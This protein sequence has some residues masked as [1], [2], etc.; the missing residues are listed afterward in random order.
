M[1]RDA[2]SILAVLVLSVSVYGGAREQETRSTA[3]SK[4]MA[5]SVEEISE[6]LK[7]LETPYSKMKSLSYNAE[8][9]RTTVNSETEDSWNFTYRAPSDIRIEYKSPR[10]RIIVINKRDMWEYLPDQRVAMHTGLSEK[11]QAERDAIILKVMSRVSVSGL[12]PGNY[13]HLV[14]QVTA[15]EK[16]GNV[17]TIKGDQSPPFM[18][19]IN[20]ARNAMLVS[21]LYDS[22][23]NLKLKTT[24]SEHRPVRKGFWMPKTIQAITSN[25][26]QYITDLVH[27]SEVSID[28]DFSDNLFVFKKPENVRVIENSGKKE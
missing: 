24:C 25:N 13:G 22:D 20:T 21:E 9:K 7:T 5:I 16:S 11:S 26:N 8:R 14:S 12:R 6:I 15:S 17:L 23:G 2:L 3:S 19:K 4:R 1:K 27:V 18:L 10:K 28:H